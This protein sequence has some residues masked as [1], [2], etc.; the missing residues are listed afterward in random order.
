MSQ[1]TAREHKAHW[2]MIFTAAGVLLLLTGTPL[3]AQVQ[4]FPSDAKWAVAPP[5][6]DERNP[7]PSISGAACSTVDRRACLAANDASNFAQLFA[8][9][10]TR[11]RPASTIQLQAA[12]L[13]QLTFKS[14][15]A[16]GVAFADDRFYVVGSR[17]QTSP[18]SDEA[19]F[20][21]FRFRPE[22]SGTLAPPPLVPPSL[23]HVDRSVRVREAITAGI[24]SNLFGLGN[25]QL[26]DFDVQGVAVRNGQMFVGFA[27]PAP[28][29]G[30][31]IMTVA[32]EAIFGSA[33]LNI[34][35]RALNLGHIGIRDLAS[36][37]TG[38]LLLTGPAGDQPGAA[39]LFHLKL[40]TGAVSLL[41][42]VVAPT[43]RRAETVLVL[44]E[45][46][47]FVRFLL[48]FDDVENGGPIEYFV[49]R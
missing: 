32:A 37:S 25:Q 1:Q 27:A 41:G 29:N 46:P 20:L 30:P 40:D 43:N 18:V 15:A 35:V 47:E 24:Q 28:A 26:Q 16:E 11:I 10:T 9:G 31:F 48:L 36:I 17:G 44:Q 21:A 33:D 6:G 49:S 45:D 34:N 38:I 39:S 5:F 22:V 2:P 12:Q 14:I 13:N 4:I 7:K 42:N 8:L 19:S 3:T 23:L